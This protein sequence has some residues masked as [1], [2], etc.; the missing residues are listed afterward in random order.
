MPR[1]TGIPWIR[2]WTEIL[3]CFVSE[4]NWLQISL[5]RFYRSL[6]A[7]DVAAPGD[8]AI[9]V[10]GVER[11]H[12]SG[13][14]ADWSVS[15]PAVVRRHV[16]YGTRPAHQRHSV[17]LH[18]AWWPSSGYREP[19]ARR[20][21]MLQV[22]HGV[23]TLGL[24]NALYCIARSPALLTRSYVLRMLLLFH[25]SAHFSD[26]FARLCVITVNNYGTEAKKLRDG[27]PWWSE[28]R[29]FRKSNPTPLGDLL[30]HDG[31]GLTY[32]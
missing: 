12:T 13:Q 31:S 27:P 19:G 28:N 24:C 1:P 23:C 17:G 29:K 21:N 4:H 30:F 18:D 8:L 16:A 14:I 3:V 7:N 25:M 5:Q 2:H 9:F 10:A 15:T 20:R 6:D 22:L 26:A 32:I 11:V